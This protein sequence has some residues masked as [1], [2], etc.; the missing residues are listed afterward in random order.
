MPVDQELAGI[1]VPTLV[2]AGADDKPIPA[3]RAREIAARM[4]GAQL[5]IVADCGHTS[6]LEQPDTITGLL[7]EFLAAVDHT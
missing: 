7:R 4:P 1:T 3:A 5:H 6:T 2:I